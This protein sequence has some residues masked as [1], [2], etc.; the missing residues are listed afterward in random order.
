MA[1]IKAIAL[2]KTRTI[3]YG[4]QSFPMFSPK[5][6]QLPKLLACTAGTELFSEHPLAQ[7]IVKASRAE[8]FEPHK[9]RRFKSIMGKRTATCLVCENET[10]L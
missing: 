4:T 3:T 10:V 8:G 6:N 2:D 7:A 9:S 5:R 1:Q